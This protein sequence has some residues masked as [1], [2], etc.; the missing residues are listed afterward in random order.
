MDHGRNQSNGKTNMKCQFC[1][2]R[3]PKNFIITEIS[4]KYN[5]QWGLLQ[6]KVVLKNFAIFTA[7]FR[8]IY[9]LQ[10]CNF[11]KKRLQH[12]CLLDKLAKFLRTVILKNI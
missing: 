4:E 11:I 1:T 9:G 2:Q 12:R 5:E 3:C 8:N 6:K 7:I 10:A